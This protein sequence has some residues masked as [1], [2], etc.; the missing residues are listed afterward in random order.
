MRGQPLPVPLPVRFAGAS[1]PLLLT[2]ASGVVIFFQMSQH[3]V[4]MKHG[5]AQGVAFF[6]DTGVRHQLSSNSAH[7][8]TVRNPAFQIAKCLGVKL[9]D[10]AFR[11]RAHLDEMLRH[12][13]EDYYARWHGEKKGP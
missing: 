13:K 6:S 2:V 11:D 10:L 12:L 8:Y 9:G 1:W 4:Q 3:F 5:E 7:V